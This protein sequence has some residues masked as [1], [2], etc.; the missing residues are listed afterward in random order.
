MSSD[1]TSIQ[2]D[3]FTLEEPIGR[4]GMAEVWRGVHRKRGL[5]VAVKVISQGDGRYS[6]AV[7]QEIRSAARLDHPGVIG[8]L[9]YGEVGHDAALA[10]R[11]SLREGAPYMVMELAGGTLRDFNAPVSWPTALR[12][13][14]S[15]LDAL[16]HAHARG[17]I[18]RDLKPSN[19]LVFS[20][21]HE[22]QYTLKI[23]DFGIAHALD[24]EQLEGNTSGFGKRVAGSPAY[25]PP[26]QFRNSWRDYGPWTDLYALGCL[27]FELASGKPPFG[28]G[29]TGDLAIA[30]ITRRPPRLATLGQWPDEFEGWVGRLLEK[31]TSRR[32]QTAADAAWALARIVSEVPLSEPIPAMLSIGPTP[33]T[34]SIITN[35]LSGSDGRTVTATFPDLAAVPST[36]YDGPALANSSPPPHPTD[37]RRIEPSS[38]PQ[39]LESAGLR[40]YGLR[41]V[42]LIGR[43]VERDAIWGALSKVSNSGQPR[44]IVLRGSAG[45]GKTRLAEWI[46]ERALEVGAASFWRAT[47]GRDSGPGEGLPRMLSEQ[48]GCV[49]LEPT[50]VLHR[51]ERQLARLDVHDEFE[52]R[53]LAEIISPSLAKTASSHLSVNHDAAARH[54]LIT[55]YV[56]WRASR[57]PVILLLDDVQ[58]GPEALAFSR[59]LLRSPPEKRVPV[60]L[61]LTAQSEGLEESPTTRTMLEELL[62]LRRAKA[63]EITGLEREE[64]Q[65]LV[66]NLLALSDDVIETL[67]AHTRGNPLFAVQVVADWVSQQLLE[68]RDGK[69][70][71]ASNVSLPI[72]KTLHAIWAGR[73]GR[74]LAEQSEWL[75]S[76]GTILESKA[77]RSALE[78]ASLLGRRV[79]LDEW[80]QACGCAG[81]GFPVRL[82]DKL[83]ARNLAHEQAGGWAFSHGLL[84][85]CIEQSI[86]P[87][88]VI[89]HH[90]AC[91]EMIRS[92]HRS[93][94]P[95]GAVRLGRH[96]TAAR[97]FDEALEP[98]LEGARYHMN[99]G[100][101]TIALSLL[102]QRESCL[103]Q[104]NA[105]SD[106]PLR[107][108]GWALR[109]RIHNFRFEFDAS[110]DWAGRLEASARQNDWTTLLAEA[111]TLLAW[112]IRQQGGLDEAAVHAEEAVGLYKQLGDLSGVA[113]ATRALAIIS[114]QRGDLD[115]AAELYTR[116]QLLFETVDDSLGVANCI[117]GLGRVV[118]LR[119]DEDTTRKLIA[120]AR[121]QFAALGVRNEVANCVNFLA[122]LDRFAGDYDAAE[123]GY[124]Q[125]MALQ[126]GIGSGDARIARFNICMVQLA[127]GDFEDAHG[128]LRALHRVLK[129][130]S[131]SW[132]ERYVRAAQLT[133]SA[134]LDLWDEWASKARALASELAD[135]GTVDPDIAWTTQRAGEVALRAERHTE[136]RTVL[137]IAAAQW[138]QLGNQD[139]EQAVRSLLAQIPEA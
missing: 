33:H 8:L 134:A 40:L 78:L 80:V 48:M 20:D 108:S 6:D 121:D 91:A 9:D 53:G 5:P 84:R 75:S 73:V 69:L 104:S 130:A 116:A 114:R 136:A 98:L 137:E 43:E 110:R 47:H 59:Q 115:N 18:H 107:G 37:W 101:Y 49:G 41:Q 129:R 45:T 83:L 128:T 113:A 126:E 17:V 30:H 32:F 95:E 124:R 127:R 97:L 109:A 58:W 23:T 34:S 36:T 25:M 125:A 2:L 93:G 44:L 81:V 118:Q 76:D 92:T 67:E 119:G 72:P 82:L 131:G 54:T 57:R 39:R 112:A 22:G 38:A 123:T 94:S 102:D 26:E 120:K 50:E 86:S 74:L 15:L 122:E 4:G 21:Q 12:T 51:V 10:S 52:R 62:E 65:A 71:A 56:A 88:N 135:S 7:R 90:K 16:A 139:A 60:L 11:R 55:R 14:L 79:E 35:E 19:I 42:P 28:F 96:L 77:V 68:V 63:I 13:L 31:R 138:A 132:L 24:P 100:D 3:E 106:D 85:E 70:L 61:L 1:R 89:A 66:R 105:P 27:A 99:R 117:Y 46:G 64:H 29:D 111:Q 103:D 133:S 87:E